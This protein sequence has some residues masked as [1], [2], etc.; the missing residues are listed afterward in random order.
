MIFERA[1]SD[2]WN[3]LVLGFFLVLIELKNHSFRRSCFLNVS[4]I[5][6]VMHMVHTAY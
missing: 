6:S 4:H 5:T 3:V 1:C 2:A